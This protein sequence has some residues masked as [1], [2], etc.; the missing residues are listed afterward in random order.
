[1]LKPHRLSRI[2]VM[3]ARIIV[4]ANPR[5]R[6]AKENRTIALIIGAIVGLCLL[7]CLLIAADMRIDL[8]ELEP[9]RAGTEAGASLVGWATLDSE[10]PADLPRGKVR[11]LGYRMD[12]YQAVPDGTPV[13]MFM[14][15]PDNSCM[16]RTAFPMRWSRY[17]WK[18]AGRFPI[19]TGAWSGRKEF[20]ATGSPMRL[21]GSPLMRWTTPRSKAPPTATS[22]S[23][24][25]PGERT[26]AVCRQ[27]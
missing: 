18:L 6:Q 14:L 7:T 5:A 22:D 26:E 11:M 20:F 23:G 13:K 12:G 17:G 9:K 25:S 24:L 19:A 15:M 16:R 27:R 3:G 8:S 21:K 2:A 1:M 4:S 10:K